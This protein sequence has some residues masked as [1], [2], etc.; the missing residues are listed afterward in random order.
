MPDISIIIP[1][2]N[3]ERYI[4][5][6][7]ESI[8]AQTF[9]NFEVLCVDDCSPDN[10][11][12]IIQ[13]FIKKDKRFKLFRHETNM[14]VG[15]ARNT[16]L[17]N[18]LGKYVVFVDPDD[19]I[20]RDMLDEIFKAF[21]VNQV[22][23]VWFNAVIHETDGRIISL[24]NDQHSIFNR[25]RFFNVGVYEL[26]SGTTYSPTKAYKAENIRSKNIYFPTD[27]VFEE[28][29]FYFKYFTNFR[30]AYFINKPFYHYCLREN[31]AVTNMRKG[32][33]KIE[34]SMREFLN[35]YEYLKKE[36]YL[37][38]YKYALCQ[39]LVRLINNRSLPN[40]YEKII[41]SAKEVFEKIDFPNSF[42]EFETLESI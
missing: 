20:E 9:K 36:N 32:D 16:G 18:A 1:V 6:C 35:I 22:D 3:V 40:Q 29:E 26:M 15:A 27:L 30:N 7:L 5:K 19:W 4:E 24:Y 33:T 14:K 39:L 11:V 13:K 34:D 21:E 28:S 42:R 17:K 2:Y 31:S 8:R 38:E 10:S 25:N 37:N 23:S 41:K 12:D